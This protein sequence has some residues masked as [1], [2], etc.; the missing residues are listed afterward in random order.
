[1]LATSSRQ[2]VGCFF[3][4]QEVVVSFGEHLRAK[5]SNCWEEIGVTQE[6]G[7]EG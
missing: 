1:M 3:G 4:W 2:D 6:G 5:R 7:L